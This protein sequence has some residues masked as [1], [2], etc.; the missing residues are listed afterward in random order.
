MLST[1]PWTW[2]SSLI[3]DPDVLVLRHDEW[4]ES[5]SIVV[6]GLALTATC[7][8]PRATHNIWLPTTTICIHP[9]VLSLGP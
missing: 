8:M 5:G 3:L 7:H 6:D 9:R 1:R 4:R 2:V